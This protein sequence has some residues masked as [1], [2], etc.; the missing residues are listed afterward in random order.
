MLRKQFF[1]AS[2][3]GGKGVRNNL[4]CA[5]S[6]I[7][8]LT[9]KLLESET[10]PDRRYKVMYSCLNRPACSFEGCIVSAHIL[11]CP[12]RHPLPP[13][14]PLYNRRTPNQNPPDGVINTTIQLILHHYLPIH[15]CRS[16]HLYPLPLIDNI[17]ARRGV[18]DQDIALRGG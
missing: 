5:P 17:Y 1:W 16:S 15:P 18:A 13:R 9:A 11:S 8:H 12:P 14:S 4:P 3:G 6:C 2:E 7:P 10:I